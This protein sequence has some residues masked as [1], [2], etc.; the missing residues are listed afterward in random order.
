M[1][2]ILMKNGYPI[3]VIKN[4]NRDEYMK[5]L[6]EAS[7]IGDKSGFIKIVAEAVDNSLDTYLYIVG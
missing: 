5:A 1:N 2:L 4:Q 6:E 3:T 7:T